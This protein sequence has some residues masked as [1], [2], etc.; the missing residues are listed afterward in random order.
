[1]S[2]QDHLKTLRELGQEF[3]DLSLRRAYEEALDGLMVELR[4]AKLV[5]ASLADASNRVS[6]D[7]NQRLHHAEQLMAA[8][9]ELALARG[10]LSTDGGGRVDDVE[11]A[12]ARA[13]ETLRALGVDPETGETLEA[14]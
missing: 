10:Q 6:L 13:E 2:H 12:V 3:G 5:L 8:W 14:T 7:Q 1:M 11:E 4:A 9:R